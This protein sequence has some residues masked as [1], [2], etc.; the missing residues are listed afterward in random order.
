MQQK[1]LTERGNSYFLLLC[2][3][4]GVVEKHGGS[5]GLDGRTNRITLG[6]PEDS[7]TECLQELKEIVNVNEGFRDFSSILGGDP[8]PD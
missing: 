4:R 3:V 8:I 6:I 7:E 5:L 1:A 2:I